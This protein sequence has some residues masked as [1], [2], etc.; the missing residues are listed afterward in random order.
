MHLPRVY[1]VRDGVIY[2]YFLNIILALQYG[3]NYITVEFQGFLA[4]VNVSDDSLRLG[5][6]WG[7]ESHL[8]I[9]VNYENG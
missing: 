5:R 2:I 8:Y 3:T 7:T 9:E 4:V 1:L 6:S